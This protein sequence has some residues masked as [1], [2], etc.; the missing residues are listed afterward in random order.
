MKFKKGQGVIV[1]KNLGIESGNDRNRYYHDYS[2][3]KI[4][5]GSRG[6]VVG[7]HYGH[8]KI[9]IKKT[10]FCLIGREIAIDDA[11]EKEQQEKLSSRLEDVLSEN[12]PVVEKKATAE[13]REF[14]PRF[15]AREEFAV[16]VRQEF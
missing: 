2:L 14:N 13:I 1:K 9:R 15:N 4:P 12:E 16:W 6:F 3:K 8:Y 11:Y 10:N 7:F 5:L